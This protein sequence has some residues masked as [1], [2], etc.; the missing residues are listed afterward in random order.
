M[1]A[2]KKHPWRNSIV[3]LIVLLPIVAVV[4]YSSFQVS[5]FECEVCIAF[6]GR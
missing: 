6:E 1:A 2:A 3:T 4:V 5:D